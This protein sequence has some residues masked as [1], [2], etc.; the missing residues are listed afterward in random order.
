MSGEIGQPGS[1]ARIYC[2]SALASSTQHTYHSAR[3][4]YLGFCSSLNITPLPVSQYHCLLYHH[5]PLVAYLIWLSI[6]SSPPPDYTYVSSVV[7]SPWDRK[8]LAGY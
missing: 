1:R 3:Q 5:S 7:Q 2:D 6:R 8:V 4:R